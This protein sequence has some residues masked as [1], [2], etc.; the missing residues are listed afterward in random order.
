MCGFGHSLLEAA[1][2]GV[3]AVAVVFLGEH[4]P[5]ARAFCAKGTATGSR[6]STARAGRSWRSWCASDWPTPTALRATGRRAAEL[7][8]GR[9]AERVAAALRRLGAAGGGAV[10]DPV[11]PR[12]AHRADHRRR[13]RHR[14]GRG[15]GHGRSGRARRA[16]RPSR[17]RRPRRRRGAGRRGE[18][19]ALDVSDLG[20]LPE[21]VAQLGPIDILVN[22][23]GNHARAPALEHGDAAFAAVLD[24]HLRGAF[25]LT[26][27][28]ARDMAARDGGAVVFISSVNALIGL[29]SAPGYA[30][31]KG[32][33]LSLTRAL[34]AEWAPLG[35]RVNAIVS[36]WI[37]TGMSQR[38]FAA[39]PARGE[40]VSNACRWDTSGP[41]RTSG[42]RPCT[43]AR[44]PRPT[45]PAPRCPSTAE[46]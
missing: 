8:D 39:D 3:P 34:A 44:R 6:C 35:V 40:R 38:I 43:S 36:G 26:R 2:L 20:A 42:A 45:S 14:A 23:A 12:R 21:A 11:P 30:A 4:V 27:E 28:V 19:V 18:G 22:N 31:A 9:G 46:R 33:Q 17:G 37:D 29:P 32:A 13:R 5:H 1:Y 16:R 15:A 41:R 24:V 10:S 25:A 7:V